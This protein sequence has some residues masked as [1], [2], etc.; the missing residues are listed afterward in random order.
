MSNERLISQLRG[1]LAELDDKTLVCITRNKSELFKPWETFGTI[2]REASQ[3]L[4]DEI[5]VT[6]KEYDSIETTP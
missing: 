2:N 3:Y 4:A 5:R 1:I 6:L